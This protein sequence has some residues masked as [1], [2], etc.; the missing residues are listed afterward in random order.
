MDDIYLSQVLFP[1]VRGMTQTTWYSVLLA[2]LVKNKSINTGIWRVQ[3]PTLLDLRVQHY[4]YWHLKNTKYVCY[5]QVRERW[6]WNPSELRCIVLWQVPSLWWSKTKIDTVQ[7]IILIRLYSGSKTYPCIIISCQWNV[8]GDP[9]ATFIGFYPKN[10]LN[11][12]I[13]H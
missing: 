1:P 6:G 11:E 5:N 3:H 13:V 8:L 7:T 10:E 4:K 12:K 2:L 9:P